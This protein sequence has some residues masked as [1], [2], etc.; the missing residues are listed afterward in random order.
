MMSIHVIPSFIYGTAWKRDDTAALVS[1]AIRCGFTAFD[2]AGQPKHYREDLVGQALREAFTSGLLKDRTNV[3]IQTKF[4]RPAAQDPTD[5][6]YDLNAPLEEQVH[7]SI[8]NSLHNLRHESDDESS[9]IDTLIL[10][11][12]FP[13]FADTLKAWR[14]FEAYVQSHR[15]RALGISN[16]PFDVL[17]ELYNEVEVKPSFVQVRFHSETGYEIP[18]RRFCAEKRV[19]FQAHKVLKGNRHLLDSDLIKDLAEDIGVDSAG[20]L[21]TCILGLSDSIR[22]VNGTKTESHMNDDLEAAKVFEQ[23]IQGSGRRKAWSQYMTRFREMIG[24]K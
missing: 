4:S 24:E 17:K 1:Q 6:P 9:Y 21:Y 18:M 3:Y 13:D 19:V 8:R 20:A 11:S 5:S 7:A 22:I 16:V 10:H 14:V 15:V 2:T 12:P 23:W